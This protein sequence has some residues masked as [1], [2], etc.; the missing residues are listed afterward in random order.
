MKFHVVHHVT[1]TLL[2]SDHDN[3][4]V[5]ASQTC[6]VAEGRWWMKQGTH[7]RD[8]PHNTAI[9]KIKICS[10]EATWHAIMSTW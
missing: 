1:L 4:G 2:I 8:R 7:F 9:S 3:E 5:M 6:R 10:T